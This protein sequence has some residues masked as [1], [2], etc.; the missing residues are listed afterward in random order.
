VAIGAIQPGGCQAMSPTIRRQW[1]G[2]GSAESSSGEAG[3]SGGELDDIT[4]PQGEALCRCWHKHVR[5][6]SAKAASGALA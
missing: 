2:A 5:F 1:P 6:C 3:E 4:F